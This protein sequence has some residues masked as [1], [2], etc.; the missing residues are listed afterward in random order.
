MLGLESSQVARLST[1]AGILTLFG[2]EYGVS[3]WLP[4]QIS[5]YHLTAYPP[6]AIVGPTLFSIP[7][8]ELFFFIIQT[9][10]VCATLLRW[11]FH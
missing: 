3:L 10:I 6:D 7:A 4:Y 11:P 8:E 2:R 1:P 9:Y 5:A